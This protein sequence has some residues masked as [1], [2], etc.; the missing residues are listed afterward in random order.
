MLFFF[1]KIEKVIVVGDVDHLTPFLSLFTHF[2]MTN[3]SAER[4]DF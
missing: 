4:Y 1:V 2:E 3:L